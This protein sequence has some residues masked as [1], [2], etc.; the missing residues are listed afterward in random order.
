[1]IQ[2]T[3]ITKEML[4]LYKRKNI[5]YGDTFSKSLDDDGLLVLKIRLMDKLG[6]FINLLKNKNAKVSDESLRDT[7]IDLAN[8]AVMGLVWI[9]NQ[10][11]N[12][13]SESIIAFSQLFTDNKTVSPHIVNEK[14]ELVKD[15]FEY[16]DNFRSRPKEELKDLVKHNSKDNECEKNLILG[17]YDSEYINE[18]DSNGKIT[19]IRYNTSGKKQDELLIKE[20]EKFLE[21]FKTD[22]NTLVTVDEI[23]DDESRNNK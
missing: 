4:D 16:N 14:K 1:M 8:Y 21:L 2:F 17:D 18:K 23:R 5:D 19:S 6:R 11:E 13:E 3:D 12:V 20:V 10:S 15:V 9:D 7:L 22:L